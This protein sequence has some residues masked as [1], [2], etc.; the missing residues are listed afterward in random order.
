MAAADDDDVVHG[1]SFYQWHAGAIGLTRVGAR[2]ATC[3]C[4]GAC[5]SIRLAIVGAIRLPAFAT[6]LLENGH[7]IRTVQELSGHAD[8]ST[9]MMYTHVLNRGALGVRSPAVQPCVDGRPHRT[10]Y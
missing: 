5:R 6:H 10:A 1:G 3:Q 4:D 2:T 9:T 8:V 7:D